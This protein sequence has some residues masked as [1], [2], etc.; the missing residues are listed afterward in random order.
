MF[1]HNQIWLELVAAADNPNQ[2]LEV[3]RADIFSWDRR[4][5]KDTQ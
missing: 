3:A 4:L 1:N 2:T 5:E